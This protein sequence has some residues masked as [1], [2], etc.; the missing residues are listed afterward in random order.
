[1]KKNFDKE[2]ALEI[3]IYGNT[4]LGKVISDD[5]CDTTRWSEIH[6]VVFQTKDQIGTDEAW[7]TSYSQG[8]TECQDESPWEYDNEVECTLVHQVEKVVKVWEAKK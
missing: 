5:I 8:A 7:Q 1:M 4:D 3:V 2:T 6:E